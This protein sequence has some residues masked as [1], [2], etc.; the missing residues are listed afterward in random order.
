MVATKASV[1]ASVGDRNFF[2]PSSSSNPSDCPTI[3]KHPNSDFSSRVCESIDL[4]SASCELLCTFCSADRLF[5]TSCGLFCQ[6]RGVGRGSMQKSRAAHRS[7]A[8]IGSAQPVGRVLISALTPL[9]TQ[10]AGMAACGRRLC[11]RAKGWNSRLGCWP[12]LHG[13]SSS[14]QMLSRPLP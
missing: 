5:S 4:Y 12:R 3:P 11:G 14:R 1:P 2:R 6:K 9:E 13:A 8:S 10:C 7:G